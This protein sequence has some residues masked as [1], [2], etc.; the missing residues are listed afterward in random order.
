MNI[1]F[2]E[3]RPIGKVNV[4]VDDSIV[5]SNAEYATSAKWAQRNYNLS[6]SQLTSIY[7]DYKN[8]YDEI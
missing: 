2:R 1:K 4:I 8:D 7:R 5:F 6:D 3:S